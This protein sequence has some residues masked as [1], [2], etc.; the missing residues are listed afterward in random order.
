MRSRNKED[1][2]VTISVC[3][4]SD[5][6]EL[7]QVKW[8]RMDSR[9]GELRIIKVNCALVSTTQR[10]KARS[11]HSII[12]ERAG[13]HSGFK[14][15]KQVEVSHGRAHRTLTGRQSSWSCPAP[16]HRSAP[17]Q[18]WMAGSQIHARPRQKP[19]G[20]L[21]CGL[22]HLMSQN[23]WQNEKR[24]ERFRRRVTAKQPWKIYS[25]CVNISVGMQIFFFFKQF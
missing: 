15:L 22:L 4:W 16:G 9:W 12:K 20:G 7:S 24:N 17:W 13:E 3:D 18:R 23:L 21:Q 5:R 14:Y 1:S 2:V 6:N 19:A 11:K 25:L 8:S 10:S